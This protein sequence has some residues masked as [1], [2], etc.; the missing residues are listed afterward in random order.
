[1]FFGFHTKRQRCD[2]RRGNH[3]DAETGVREN[4]FVLVQDRPRNRNCQH[5]DPPRLIQLH[6]IRK[7]R[8]VYRKRHALAKPEPQQRGALVFA[9]WKLFEIENPCAPHNPE[10][11]APSAPVSA[12]P[13]R[14][15]ARE[16]PDK[17]AV[18]EDWA[19]W[20]TDLSRALRVSRQT[21][22]PGGVKMLR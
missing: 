3:P 14:R 2:R 17:A 4:R 15:F 6:R 7:L 13:R 1:P 10:S 16:H 21:A 12:G 5:L 8:F 20:E 22:A 18:S 19:C 11:Q 9:R